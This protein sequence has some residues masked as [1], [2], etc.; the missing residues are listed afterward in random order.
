MSIK[1]QNVTYTYMIGTPYEKTAIHDISL[2]IRQREFVGVIG[3][4]GSG[5]S[6]LMQHLNG[7]LKPT[8]GE[9]VVD[10][11]DLHAKTA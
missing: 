6:T 8:Q 5:K 1:L 10:G 3:H 7:L 2:E 9:V 4:T 11:V